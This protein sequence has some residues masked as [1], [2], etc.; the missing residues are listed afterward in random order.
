MKYGKLKSI[1]VIMISIFGLIG[2]AGVDITP[3]THDRAQNAHEAGSTDKGYIVYEPAI[4]VEVSKKEVCVA[5]D[6]KGNCKVQ[7]TTCSVGAPFVMPDYK[8]PYLVNVK[9][10]FG[11]SGADITITDGWRLGNVKDNSD[12]T[13]ILDMVG[14]IVGLG[15]KA[16]NERPA[17][18]AGSCK[19]PGLYRMDIENNTLKLTEMH[20]Y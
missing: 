11:K 20:L 13:A 19:A 1:T 10:G 4:F 5:K 3:I 15:S 16:F 8:K 2:C 12:N 7:E 18:K 6:D 17:E 14:K 9:S